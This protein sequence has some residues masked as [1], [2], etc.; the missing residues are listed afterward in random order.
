MLRRTPLF[1][2]DSDSDSE[3]VSLAAGSPLPLG[4]DTFYKGAEDAKRST[5][6][7]D[8]SD[9]NTAMPPLGRQGVT[10]ARQN[11]SSIFSAAKDPAPASTLSRGFTGALHGNGV[12]S[13]VVEA[14]SF[15]YSGVSMSCTAV[16]SAA[17]TTAA[18]T[19]SLWSSS[20]ILKRL[21]VQVYR[22]QLCLG[23][24]VAM[25]RAPS[26]SAEC[27]VV[28][29]A[30]D[31][32]LALMNDADQLLCQLPLNIGA[33][34]L[35]QNPDEPQY[36]SLYAPLASA[37]AVADVNS[38]RWWTLMCPDR[39]AAMEFLVAAYTVA[40]YASHIGHRS[41]GEESVTAPTAHTGFSAVC[42][43]ESSS[44]SRTD[45]TA[46]L[47]SVVVQA[48]VPATFWWRTWSLRHFQQF[49]PYF[50]PMEIVEE[51]APEM[52]QTFVPR[53]G[54][55]M[56]G[57]EKG[58]LGMAKGESRLVFM[59]LAD[60]QVIHTPKN[61][62]G[63]E[64][65]L[66]RELD[67]PV[68]T[69]VTCVAPAAAFSHRFTIRSQNA[70]PPPPLPSPAAAQ[71][72]AAGSAVTC[73][74]GTMAVADS[75]TALLQQLVLLQSIQQGQRPSL[76]G[77]QL[78]LQS[79][80]QQMDRVLL[81]LASLNER[82]DR[83]DILGSLQKNNK[84]V[85]QAMK[86]VM[87]IAP[88]GDVPY[89]DAVKDRDGLLAS[90]EH[91]RSK[92]EEANENYQR[93]LEVMNRYSD[94]AKELEQ[95]VRLQQECSEERLRDEAERWRLRL[96]SAT[97]QHRSDLESVSVEQFT[98]GKAVGLEEGYR[99]GYQA[100]LVAQND[101]D[102]PDKW[103]VRL[104]EKEKELVNT[105]AALQDSISQHDRD[106]LQLRA[107]IDVLSQL[108]ESQNHQ[109]RNSDI[110]IPEEAVQLQCKRLK[111]AL[112]NVYTAVE[113]KLY[114]LPE[115]EMG[116]MPGEG[117]TSDQPPRR[118]VAVDDV[119]AVVALA[120]RSEATVAVQSLKTEAE[121]RANSNEALRHLTNERRWQQVSSVSA[122]L[123]PVLSP[124][125]ADIARGTLGNLDP[126]T[127]KLE[128]YAVACGGDERVSS[129][130]APGLLPSLKEGG[131]TNTVDQTDGK[132]DALDVVDSWLRGTSTTLGPES[133]RNPQSSPEQLPTQQQ[134]GDYQG[135]STQ[136]AL[137]AVHAAS[138]S[139]RPAKSEGLDGGHTGLDETD[140]NCVTES[141]P[142]LQC[143]MA[144]QHSV[145]ASPPPPR[146]Q[147]VS[148]AQNASAHGASS[149][150]T[151][152]CDVEA[153][154]SD[155]TQLLAG[156]LPRVASTLSSQTPCHSLNKLCDSPEDQSRSLSNSTSHGRAAMYL[157]APEDSHTSLLDQESQISGVAAASGG[158]SG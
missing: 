138:A 21:P 74:T 111:R 79:L 104:L 80:G 70:A 149:P 135:N 91:Y 11:L 49:S 90:V 42:K 32:M 112:N 89:E 37:K 33:F 101:G 142:I 35:L 127:V 106:R 144:S 73:Q 125:V 82:V 123:K 119:L 109:M 14:P 38:L 105:Q 136:M 47:G 155:A 134:L 141:V 121:Q 99:A 30:M 100:A 87:G 6:E 19:T 16:P 31:P 24:C 65:S 17:A 92:Y 103:K 45:V 7:A 157:V 97:S 158:S 128:G 15:Q 83:I 154:T 39:S 116:A 98:S 20:Q 3:I 55:V 107:E 34:R 54:T 63:S 117:K 150:S 48:D 66:Q 64:G 130:F 93:A 78:D 26:P 148:F 131:D 126:K 129:T 10:E 77:P 113:N 5:D 124:N 50:L 46:S 69:H 81:Q 8:L 12:S 22:E 57:L 67:G 62:R 153:P 72:H 156:T 102:A 120:I 147:S 60:T 53:D 96:M 115:S 29:T 58:V 51:V 41:E 75:T 40:Q 68:V 9:P 18:Q 132:Q 59:T 94:R 4:H 43:L 122:R 13:V 52:P 2:S 110:R 61:G 145:N 140:V 95:D 152:G 139:F 56:R 23:T 84:E 137:S 151:F 71:L 76:G 27:E 44:Q 143:S 88:Q 118:R 36:L 1:A 133:Q 85:E 146:S 28:A 25:I 108:I 114:D 86:R